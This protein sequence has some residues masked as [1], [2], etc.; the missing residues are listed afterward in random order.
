MEPCGLSRQWHWQ[1][2]E[3]HGIGEIKTSLPPLLQSRVYGDFRQEKEY[4]VKAF[5]LILDF[6]DIQHHEA[7]AA[8]LRESLSEPG[9]R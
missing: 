1:R 9:M 7:P 6:Y 5:D 8:D 3:V 4:F 2:I